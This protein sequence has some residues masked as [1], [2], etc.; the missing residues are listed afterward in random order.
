M[1]ERKQD[2]LLGIRTIGLREWADQA[3]YNRYEATPYAALDA[4]FQA[5][6][7]T[8]ND[9]VVDFGCGRGR[10]AFYI[11]NRFRIPVTGIEANETTLE[12]ALDNKYMYRRKAK[13][14]NATINFEY[15]LAQ[16]YDIKP[17]DNCF[18]FFNPFSAEIFKKV[19][20]NILHSVRKHE[21]TIDI[22]LYYPMPKFKQVLR[23][24][25]AFHI[26]NKIKVPRMLDHRE[27]FIIY[28]YN[29]S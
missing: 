16:H 7:F 25:T 24:H 8:E 14:I 9:Q 4:L 6:R 15:G 12:E 1:S 22:I 23:E 3:D 17:T 29:V 11:H 2:Q 20:T 19:V 18:Y 21:R 10:V 5:Y 27:K 26:I 28:R 13:Q